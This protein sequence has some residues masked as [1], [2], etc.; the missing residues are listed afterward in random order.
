MDLRAPLLAVPHDRDGMF[1]GFN[2]RAIRLVANT[3]RLK[4]RGAWRFMTEALDGVGFVSSFVGHFADEMDE[5]RHLRVA[6]GELLRWSVEMESMV[7]KAFEEAAASKTTLDRGWQNAKYCQ[8]WR[9]TPTPAEYKS[10]RSEQTDLPQIDKDDPLVSFKYFA[11]LP[12]VRPGIGDSEAAKRRVQY[13]GKDRHVADLEGEGDACNKAFSICTGL[14][15]GVFNVVCPHVI[16][17]GFR[18]LFRAESVGEAVS[19]VLERFPKLP[20]VVFYD[21]ACKFDKNAMRRVRAIFRDHKVRCVLDRPHSITHGCSPIYM[22]D[23]SLGTTAGVATQAAEVSHSIAVVNRTSLA[24]MSPSTYMLHKMTQVAFMNLRKLYRLH[25]DIGAGENAH[26]ALAPFF[27][28]KVAHQ[29][30]R[31]S[32][33]SCTP[34]GFPT[35]D[36]DEVLGDSIA[37]NDVAAGDLAD[38]VQLHARAASGATAEP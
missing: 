7:D 9:G 30:E 8:R 13:R 15:Q 17:L 37:A 25:G 3:M 24:Y 16:T 18:C 14:T 23:E 4:S 29:C 28:S 38:N 19:I 35:A 27:H 31:A 6:I 10:W 21:V 26:V 20:A 32:V 36:G 11:S 5:D 22:P 1:T 12:S 34:D 2:E 33:C